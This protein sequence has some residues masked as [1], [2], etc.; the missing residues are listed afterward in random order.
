[1]GTPPGLRYTAGAVR[2]RRGLHH[3]YSGSGCATAS[4]RGDRL[5]DASMGKRCDWPPGHRL[6]VGGA[7]PSTGFAAKR[8]SSG[9]GVWYAHALHGPTLETDERHTAGY[10]TAC[11]NPAMTQRLRSRRALDT[12]LVVASSV[13]FRWRYDDA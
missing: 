11:D 4:I 2:A 12:L 10:R 5:G 6:P 1:M 7:V 9:C 3:Q 8:H 13:C